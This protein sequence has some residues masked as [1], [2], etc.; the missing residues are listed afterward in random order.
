MSNCSAAHRATAHDPGSAPARC[1]AQH[2]SSVEAVNVN[3]DNLAVRAANSVLM[4]L[5]MAL[6]NLPMRKAHFLFCGWWAACYGV[7]NIFVLQPIAGGHAA[8]WTCT[9]GHCLV[10]PFMSMHEPPR[11][12][13]VVL[14]MCGLCALH[15]CLYF[16]ARAVVM[17]KT[18]GCVAFCV[19]CDELPPPSAS[20]SVQQAPSEEPRYSY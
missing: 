7:F 6:N 13:G 3:I 19:R 16:V 10:Y 11:G 2:V 18:L 8:A 14:W 1:T 4:V 5:E 17:A 12:L 15:G 20:R 9:S